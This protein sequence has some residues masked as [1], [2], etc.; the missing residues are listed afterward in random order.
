MCLLQ[1]YDR[2]LAKRLIYGLSHS[3]EAEEDMIHRLRVCPV[4]C[5]CGSDD[6]MSTLASVWIPVCVQITTNAARY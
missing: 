2:A 6:V 1:C 4:S 3:N 5:G